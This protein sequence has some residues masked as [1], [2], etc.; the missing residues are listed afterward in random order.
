MKITVKRS[1]LLW[2]HNSL[3]STYMCSCR[4]IETSSGLPWKSL[5]IFVNLRIFSENVRKRLSGI[6]TT[7]GELSEIL[8]SVRKSSENRQKRSLRSLV[9]YPF[10][11]EKKNSISTC[12]HVFSAISLICIHRFSDAI[13]LT[14]MLKNKEFWFK[15]RA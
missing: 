7:F 13:I 2:L 14:I 10:E 9:R 5:V 1:P 3:K 8:L 15:T 6:Q 12:S 4:K 11:H